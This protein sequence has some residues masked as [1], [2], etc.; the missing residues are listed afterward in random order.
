MKHI[1]NHCPVTSNRDIQD[2]DID[3]AGNR[4][5]ENYPKGEYQTGQEIIREVL[6][7]ERAIS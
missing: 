5:V 6:L 3:P 1:S 7:L 2:S 4:G